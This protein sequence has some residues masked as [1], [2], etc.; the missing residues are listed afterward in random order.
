M[1]TT[2]LPASDLATAPPADGGTLTLVQSSPPASASLFPSLVCRSGN[3]VDPAAPSTG[4]ITIRLP[5]TPGPCRVAAGPY[6]AKALEDRWQ[7][8]RK[9]LRQCQA[10]FSEEGVHELRVATRRLLAQFVLLSN[11][12]PSASLE[13][14]RR[15]LKRRLADLGDLRD[16]QVQRLFVEQHADRF[17]ETDGLRRW[18]RRRER[19]LIKS[20]VGKVKHFSAKKLEKRL[21]AITEGLL[22]TRRGARTQ[23]R[24]CAAAFRA[25][26]AAFAEAVKRRRAIDLADLGTIHQ[27]RIAFKRFRYMVE[28]LSP[29]LT[30]LTKRQLRRL[31][32]YQRKMGIIQDLEVIQRCVRQFAREQPGTQAELRPFCS[33][34]RQRRRRAL[35]G[36]VRSADGIIG[37]WPPATLSGDGAK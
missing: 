1:E 7:T 29:G 14:A 3:A 12:A 33:Y 5:A 21:A 2:L 34:L 10:R 15:I 24:L 32:Y 23:E 22:A 37:F 6:L 20:A 19:R 13:K 36:F 18:L 30:G 28:S 16:T 17:P 25:T 26:T 27:T 35:Q 8:Y 4:A 11:V 9:Q 31:A